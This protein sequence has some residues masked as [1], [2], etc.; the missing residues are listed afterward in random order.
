MAIQRQLHLTKSAK[1]LNVTKQPCHD[2]D[3]QRV[4]ILLSLV[5]V[6]TTAAPALYIVGQ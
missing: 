5:I 1:N 4:P 2:G 3:K 6:D